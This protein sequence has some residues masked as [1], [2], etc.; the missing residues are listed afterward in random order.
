MGRV[1]IQGLGVVDIEGDAP[2]EKEIMFL[3]ESSILEA[4]QI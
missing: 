2:N 1:N 4:T 3:L